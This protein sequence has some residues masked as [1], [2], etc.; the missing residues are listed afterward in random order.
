MPRLSSEQELIDGCL[1][2][3]RLAQ[4]KAYEQFAPRMLSLCFR[5]MKDEFE[6]EDAMTNGFLKVFSKIDQFKSEG[7]FEGWV[8][9][10]MVNECLNQL[11]KQRLMYADIE[12]ENVSNNKDFSVY[13]SELDAEELMHF[14]HQ[15]PAGYGAVFNMYA[16]EGYSHK[17]IAEMLGINENTSKSQLSRAR[18]FLQKLINEHDSKLNNIKHG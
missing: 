12:I 11:R 15:L 10:I 16:I 5:Y 1:K 14:V 4:R 6:A 8:R 17:E 18:N 7:S 13:E 3:D 2:K 9:R